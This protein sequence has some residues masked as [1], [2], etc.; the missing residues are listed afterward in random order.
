[1]VEG[2]VKIGKIDDFPVRSMRRVQAGDRIIVL[3]NIDGRLYAFSNSCTHRGGALDEGELDSNV[4][5]C[6]LHGGQF[7][8]RTGKVVSPPPTKDLVM[9]D[10]Q[11]QGS[12]VLVKT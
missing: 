9:Y 11:V 4:V 6:P 7:D 2:L 12:D 5:I 8:V 3:A 1:M 10:V